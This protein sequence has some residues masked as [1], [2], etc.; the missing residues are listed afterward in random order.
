MSQL[1][2]SAS[3]T[4]GYVNAFAPEISYLLSANVQPATRCVA[5]LATNPPADGPDALTR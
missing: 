3:T 5:S 1:R 4:R 2:Q